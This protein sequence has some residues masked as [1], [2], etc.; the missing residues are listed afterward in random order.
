MACPVCGNKELIVVS[1]RW[2]T[3][4]ACSARWLHRESGVGMVIRLPSREQL[5]SG[6]DRLEP[7]RRS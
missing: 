3:C 4:S 6:L 7:D 5:D 1:E 2:E